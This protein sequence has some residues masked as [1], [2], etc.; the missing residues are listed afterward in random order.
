MDVKSLKEIKARNSWSQTDKNGNGCI[1]QW[2]WMAKTLQK[3]NLHEVISGIF[4]SKFQQSHYFRFRLLLYCIIL[5]MCQTVVGIKYDP[6][7]SR[8]FLDLI[9]RREFFK[10]SLVIF[11]NFFDLIFGGNLTLC[12]TMQR[13]PMSPLAWRSKAHKQNNPFSI[14]R[15]KDCPS[16]SPSFNTLNEEH[17]TYGG[18]WGEI[19]ESNLSIQLQHCNYT[20]VVVVAQ[21]TT[22]HCKF[23]RFF[24]SFS[25]SLRLD[26]W[27]WNK[28][29]KW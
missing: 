16:R 1:A 28:I 17:G 18:G 29:V 25:V 13:A 12:P 5:E 26:S 14:R 9:F 27:G 19:D 10:V 7:S 8:I 22:A 6:S 24:C 23:Y 15:W 4:P 11:T 20:V 2:L 3:I 21:T